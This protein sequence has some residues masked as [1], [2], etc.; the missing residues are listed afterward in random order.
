MFG[1]PYY[2][3]QMRGVAV[4]HQNYVNVC[5]VDLV[6]D[7]QGRFKVLDDNARTPS[8]VSYVV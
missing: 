3:E 2:R 4:P 8:G 7:G 1:N 6:R 5:G